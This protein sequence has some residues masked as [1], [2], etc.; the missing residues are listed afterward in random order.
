MRAQVSLVMLVALSACGL[1]AGETNRQ[2]NEGSMNAVAR[3]LD[4]S[5]SPEFR[6]VK[7]IG[8]SGPVTCGEFRADQT[9]AFRRF[10]GF[11]PEQDAILETEVEPDLFAGMWKASC[12][13]PE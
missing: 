4:S 3:A 9:V 12:G 1:A 10:I 2:W 13:A 11:G 8:T 5:A 6:N 7:V